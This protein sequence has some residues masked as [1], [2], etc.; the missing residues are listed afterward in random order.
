[1]IDTEGFQNAMDNQGEEPLPA[2]PW[3]KPLGEAAFPGFIG[4]MMRTIEPHT[5]SDIA[6]ILVQFLSAFGNA[7]G[8][9]PFFLVEQT[10]HRAIL[11]A[12][13]VGKSAK[14]R[15]GTAWNI[16]KSLFT[17]ADPVWVKRIASGLSSGEGVINYVRDDI[18]K[19]DDDGSEI[20]IA[21]GV[22]DKRLLVVESEFAS[23]LKV[24]KREGNTMTAVRIGF[25][26]PGN[27]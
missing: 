14:S 25:T 11:F 3:P 1:M 10:R 22:S 26:T 27:N 24:A 2:V 16:I 18:T 15:K 7:V 12:V 17:I 19:P 23:P 6:A 9:G 21:P 20:V 8:D 4:D 13:I 5:E